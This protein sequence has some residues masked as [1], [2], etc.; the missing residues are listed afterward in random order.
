MLRYCVIIS[1]LL[2]SS[3]G[4]NHHLKRSKYHLNKAVALGAKIQSDTVFKEIPVKVLIPGNSAKLDFG[5]VIDFKSFQNVSDLND[6][7]VREIQDLKSELEPNVKELKK[8]NAELSRV[9][10]RLATGFAKDS[11]YTF[12]PDT[13]TEI[14]VKMQNGVP[15]L[16]KHSTKPLVVTRTIHAPIAVTNEVKPKN[17]YFEAVVSGIILGIVLVLVVWY[18]SKRANH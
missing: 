17:R 9:K 11:T 13:L 16:L 4:V 6:S 15:V 7:L 14:S 5:A 18:Y 3:C 2:L 1:C 10:K 12:K 8:A